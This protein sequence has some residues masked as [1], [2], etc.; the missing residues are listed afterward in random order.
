[1]TANARDDDR[2]ACLAAGMDGFV[3]KPVNVKA[4][5]EALAGACHAG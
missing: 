2:Q 1:M 5:Q 3:S 4:L